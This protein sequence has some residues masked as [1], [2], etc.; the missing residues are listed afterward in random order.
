M[1]QQ[2]T[3]TSLDLDCF[4][5][6]QEA[7]KG[8]HF[9]IMQL[10]CG[11]LRGR[12]SHVGI[13]DFAFSV[14]DFN[15]AIR[16]QRT[17][18]DDRLL[19]GMLLG[20]ADRVTQW[21]WDMR[22]LDVIVIPPLTEHHAV[23]RGASS[24]AGIRLDPS[25][26]PL[27]FAGDPWLSDPENWRDKSHFRAKPA[28]GQLAAQKLPLMIEHLAR[29]GGALSPG[30][31]QFWKRTIVECM[32]TTIASALPSEEARHLPSAIKLVRHVED[33]LETTG[34]RP[35][36][37]SEI[38]LELCAS[39]RSLHRAFNEVFGIGPVTF[40]RQKR[41][42]A[43]H[44]ILTQRAPGTTTVAEIALEQGF[45]ELGRF[46]QYYRTM[47]GEY[48]SETLNSARRR[49]TRSDV[50]YCQHQRANARVTQRGRTSFS[51]PRFA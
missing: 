31:A 2:L 32:A 41:L 42:C 47:F 6:L 24:Y 39:R 33:Y 18:A 28:V 22:P 3:V 45:I 12:L 19:I 37:L 11:K 30:A 44:T 36:H 34:E 48:P 50:E 51:T 38:C 8:T 26:L 43:V 17:P 5:G 29:R 49:S 25:E 27:V 7:V 46:S 35:L 15:V 21:S 16:A 9:D 14:G 23:H 10:G 40:L 1:D 13:G 4:E 20:S